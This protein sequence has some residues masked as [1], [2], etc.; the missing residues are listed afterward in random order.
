MCMVHSF[1]HF[2]IAHS[3]AYIVATRFLLYSNGTTQAKFG[4]TRA[5]IGSL[6][7]HDEPV[8]PCSSTRDL[9]S[10]LPIPA[11]LPE[12]T[13][14][15]LLTSSWSSS[16]IYPLPMTVTSSEKQQIT[17]QSLTRIVEAEVTEPDGRLMDMTSGAKVAHLYWEETYV[18][19]FSCCPDRN[20]KNNCA[21]FLS[22]ISPFQA[23][24][25]LITPDTSRAT[26]PVED[27]ELF[28]PSRP[29][30]SLGDSILL[31]IGKIPSYLDAAPKA[32]TD[33]R[34]FFITYAP[35][36]HPLSLIISRPFFPLGPR[37]YWLPSLLKH[38]YIALCFIAQSSYE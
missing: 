29:S 19:L 7:N 3:R 22:D 5:G 28:D 18:M 16:A 23:N 11:I 34:T 2:K 1:S 14:E 8:F 36:L 17:A 33:A 20:L 37:R 9:K 27:I 25:C 30:L 4:P 10:P 32:L 21:S 31:L 6:G 26:T 38:A 12:V 13:V 35:S 15:S 24:S